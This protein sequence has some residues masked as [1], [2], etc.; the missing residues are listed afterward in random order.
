M[1]PDPTDATKKVQCKR[2]S[3]E[4]YEYDIRIRQW[5]K[6]E[7]SR[8]ADD[9]KVYVVIWQQCS[10]AMKDRVRGNKDFHRIDAQRDIINLLIII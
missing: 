3:V 7:Q 1:I 8:L 6:D 2:E 9:H 5:Y 10:P 4:F